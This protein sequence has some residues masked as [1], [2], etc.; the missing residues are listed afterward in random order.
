M[1]DA[2]LDARREGLWLAGYVGL[3]AA[4]L[5]LL[6]LREAFDVGEPL[7]VLG[8]I[9]IGFSCLAFLATRGTVTLGVPVREPRAECALLLAYLLLVIVPWLALVAGRVRGWVASPPVGEVLVLATKL[10]IFV[11]LPWAFFARRGYTL[12]DFFAGWGRGHLRAGLIVAAAA[13]A[14]QSSFGRG[15][16]DLGSLGLSPLAL[17]AGVTLAF[18]W[19]VVEVG[20]VEEFFFRALV[21]ERAAALFRS[22]AAGVVVMA[23]VFGL[24]HAPGLY[25]RTAATQEGL[26]ANP[27]LFAAVGYS[28]VVTSVAGLFFGVLWA[29]TR[30]LALVCLVHAAFDLVPDLAPFL[31]TF[32]RA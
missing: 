12:R 15:L 1:K 30:N 18:V 28:L 7:L 11:A 24:A 27:S 26:T 10:A 6:H 19:L 16:G 2:R 9:G 3:Y 22:P 32:S 21:Q 20:L 23:V 5:A 29:R 8:V 25:L 4:V 17:G 13:V 14:F 31:R